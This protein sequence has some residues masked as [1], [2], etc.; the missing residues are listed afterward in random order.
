MAFSLW[1][2][3]RG[4][5]ASAFSPNLIPTVSGKIPVGEEKIA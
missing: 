2:L 4:A 1:V 3:V 5:V